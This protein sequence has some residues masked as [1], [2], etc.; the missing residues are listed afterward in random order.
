MQYLPIHTDHPITNDLAT[1]RLLRAQPSWLGLTFTITNPV[2]VLSLTVSQ[3][4]SL[5]RCHLE[6][7]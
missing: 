3:G 5:K 1:S 4:L 6:D 2:W 7:Q